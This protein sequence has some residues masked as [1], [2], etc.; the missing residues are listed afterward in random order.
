MLMEDIVRGFQTCQLLADGNWLREL[1]ERRESHGLH[2]GRRHAAG[3]AVGRAHVVD[4]GSEA[5]EAAGSARVGGAL[6]RATALDVLD[7]A[8]GGLGAAQVGL[9]LTGL[10]VVG[11]SRH[12]LLLATETG[13]HA[14]HAELGQL[15][16]GHHGELAAGQHR[17]LAAETAHET[18]L[19]RLRGQHTGLAV[20]L[21][22]V[23]DIG[24]EAHRSGGRLR[25]AGAGRRAA[26]LGGL[27]VA[28]AGHGATH[29]GGRVALLHRVGLTR[30]LLDCNIIQ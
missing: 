27:D 30:L 9:S 1:R 23:L 15:A 22:L 21:R 11:R 6:S 12:H 29:V 7:V 20:G 13:Q 19:L 8:A 3:L 5:L 2:L 26:T 24:L 4:A 17:E 14:G 18:G 10:H 25:A 16:A 28:T